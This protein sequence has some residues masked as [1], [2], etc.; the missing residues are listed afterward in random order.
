[1][2]KHYTPFPQSEASYL[3]SAEKTCI[4]SVSLEVPCVMLMP[5]R[6]GCWKGASCTVSRARSLAII[7]FILPPFLIKGNCIAGCMD[8]LVHLGSSVVQPNDPCTQNASINTLKNAIERRCSLYSRMMLLQFKSTVI[9]VF[10][11]WEVRTCTL[12]RR[13]ATQLDVARP[14][15]DN[16][17]GNLFS[18]RPLVS[19]HSCVFTAPRFSLIQTFVASSLYTV[20]GWCWAAVSQ[21][22][23]IMF[24]H[25]LGADHSILVSCVIYECS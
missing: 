24:L 5:L 19:V 25:P 13:G 7:P 8:C 1:M 11:G 3:P 23:T 4:T 14:I 9:Q 15:R 2:Q 21:R 12:Q 16:R 22:L 18:A 10:W 20:W 6:V 17:H